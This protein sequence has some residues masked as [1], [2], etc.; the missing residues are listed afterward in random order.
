MH[1]KWK[2]ID[3]AIACLFVVFL[4]PS[5]VQG[6]VKNADDRIHVVDKEQKSISRIL[7]WKEHVLVQTYTRCFETGN[8]KLR[9]WELDRNSCVMRPT[10]YGTPEPVHT[11]GMWNER[12]VGIYRKGKVDVVLYLD[13][14]RQILKE[15]AVEGWGCVLMCSNKN[16]LFVSNGYSIVVI[17]GSGNS[18]ERDLSREVGLIIIDGLRAMEAISDRVLLGYDAG[19]WGGSLVELKVSRS[20][21]L[22]TPKEV[23]FGNVNT[24]LK[25]KDDLVWI[26]CGFAHGI[27]ETGKFHSY[28]GVKL[29]ELIF[30]SGS[31][32]VEPDET[33][34]DVFVFPVSTTIDGIAQDA[35]GSCI[36]V[37][38]HAGI[39]KCRENPSFELVP[40]WVGDM[41]IAYSKDGWNFHSRPKGLVI[42]GDRY[43]VATQGSGVLEFRL[44]NTGSLKFV[45]QHVFPD[46]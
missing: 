14:D 23:L 38:N 21:N 29:R 44:T 15:L 46:Q 42:F 25:S 24:L 16:H 26:S 34:D 13:G 3:Q 39:Y 4:L 12:P 45:G 36:L 33:K 6:S 2:L 17:S 41:E 9:L 35:D 7:I 40:L 22:Q 19:E 20:G 11:V 8:Y 18:S 32:S 28:D 43:F 30:Q 5:L 10:D 31:M 27:T 37:A 1:R